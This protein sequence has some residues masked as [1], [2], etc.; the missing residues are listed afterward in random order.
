SSN[1]RRLCRAESTTS[2]TLGQNSG[3]FKVTGRWHMNLSK[4]PTMHRQPLGCASTCGR[5]VSSLTMMGL[6]AIA[7]RSKHQNALGNMILTGATDVIST[8]F[9]ISHREISEVSR[10][11]RG[12]SASVS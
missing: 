2:G 4:T 10:T 1:Q 8:V 5:K 7:K 12:L 3:T 9:V 11:R 6:L